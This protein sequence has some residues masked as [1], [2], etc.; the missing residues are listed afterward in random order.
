MD[1]I[2]DLKNSRDKYARVYESHKD[3]IEKLRVILEIENDRT[4][5]YSEAS[6][7]AR[8]LKHLYIALA[9]NKVVVRGGLKNRDRLI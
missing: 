8:H 7:F 3:P 2:K 1:P 5:S 6:D 9:G 4:F